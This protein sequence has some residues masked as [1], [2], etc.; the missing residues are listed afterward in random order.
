M[1]QELSE[2]LAAV[3]PVKRV[4]K[5][6]SGKIVIAAQLE[7]DPA[8]SGRYMTGI[9]KEWQ[10]LGRIVAMQAGRVIAANFLY[11]MWCKGTPRV[12]ACRALACA[13]CGKVVGMPMAIWAVR[14]RLRAEGRSDTLRHAGGWSII[15]DHG[16]CD[17]GG[18]LR[19]A[20]D[21]EKRELNALAQKALRGIEAMETQVPKFLPPT[22]F[23]VVDIRRA[24]ALGPDWA[25]FAAVMAK[26][27]K[28]LVPHR[29]G[30]DESVL[31]F[32]PG[33]WVGW[34]DDI[35]DKAV[36]DLFFDDTVA[37]PGFNPAG[38]DGL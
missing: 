7:R 34:V 9:T 19:E 2:A 30:S 20:V 3:E 13:K 5:I 32:N 25:P 17:C 22:A 29:A 10:P 36:R 27:G 28:A 18:R 15:R 37:A 6:P 35:R 8:V 1:N 12:A 33:Y 14:E 24:S 21:V 11:G 16:M 23:A 4:E 26:Q 38:V 31:M